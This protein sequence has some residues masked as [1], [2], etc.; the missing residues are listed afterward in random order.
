[1]DKAVKKFIYLITDAVIVSVAL[2]LAFYLRFDGNIPPGYFH[3]FLSYWWLTA[4]IYLACFYLSG[5]YRV[6]WHFASVFDVLIILRGVI[7][8][9]AA[10]AV[11]HYFFQMPYYPRS[12]II[13]LAIFSIGG[14][15]GS[16]MLLK[17]SPEARESLRE[18]LPGMRRRMDRVLIFGAGSSGVAFIRELKNRPELRMKPV[19]F[20]DDD[21][22]K[23]GMIIY[24]LQVLGDRYALPKMIHQFRIDRVIIAIPS[25][26]L[27]DIR[28]IVEIIE[29]TGIVAQTIPGIDE[30]VSGK[31]NISAVR[32]VNVRDLLGRDEIEEDMGEVASFLTGR[33]VLVTGAGGSIGSELC[34][35]IMRYKPENLVMLDNS[36]NSLFD[37]EVEFGEKMQGHGY[38][39]VV[40]SIQDAD[41][42]QEIFAAYR[43]YVVFHAAAYKHVPMMEKNPEEALK[44]NVFG[45][46]NTAR[47]AG[48]YGARKFVLISTDK[49][50]NPT[51]VM[52]ASKRAAEKALQMAAAEAGETEFIAVRFGNVLGSRGSVIP[53]FKR[54][55]AAGGPV[56]VTHPEMVRFFM[57]IPEA[58]RLVIQAGSIGKGGEVFVLDMGEP[59]KIAALAEDLIRQSG[60]LPGKDIEIVYTGIRP[61][62]KLYE[63][64]LTSEEGIQAT[65]HQ[66][67]FQADIS[68]EDPSALKAWLCEVEGLLAGHASSEE[69]VR[70]LH[71]IV[72]FHNPF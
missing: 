68:R 47:A 26:S 48:K 58:V 30:I 64:I 32:N 10:L 3:M 22:K 72:R 69:Y 50:V 2:Y 45:T 9:S 42:L 57:T 71:K 13:M 23:Q 14:V 41:R 49:A 54:Q 52:G 24:G 34:R 8:A 60:L 59:V 43:P 33:R 7:F 35:Q 46:L 31:V 66:K 5:M 4:L 29:P 40:A 16:R 51:S 27:K 6:V 36:E 28:E 70:I 55:I 61:G 38:K 20:I 11:L 1:M 21:Q 18:L 25:S 19:G 17:L 65:R 15:A 39:T 12:V 37:M 67:I 63:E 56:T 44:N 62:E 53:L